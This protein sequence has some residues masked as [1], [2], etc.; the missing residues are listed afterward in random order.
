MDLPELVAPAGSFEHAETALR[1]GAD[2]IYAGVDTLNL[3]ARGHNFEPDALNELLALCRRYTA[4]LYLTLN[5]WADESHL[6]Q[7]T[8][9]LQTLRTSRLLPHAF[10]V[11]D[12]GI[13]SLCRRLCPDTPLH[14]STQHGTCNSEAMKFW[15]CRGVN[16]FVLPRELTCDQIA[17]LNATGIAQTEIFAHGAMCVSISGRCL[18]GA[19]LQGRHPNWGDC[20][21]PCRYAYR[22]Q[23][24]TQTTECREDTLDIQQT[25]DATYLLNSKDLNTLP[26]LNRLVDTGVTAIKIEG[27]NK[28]VHYVASVVHTYRAALDSMRNGTGNYHARSEWIEELESVPHR[29]YTTGFY[30]NDYT[31][32]EITGTKDGGR[33]RIVAIV[34]EP[35]DAHT[36]LA[37]VKHPFECDTGVDVLSSG[38]KPA[39][40]KTII[41]RIEDIKGNR[42]HRAVTNRIV[43]VTTE[44]PLH[45]GDIFR[46]T[47]SA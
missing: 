36:A 33:K 37:D 28:S 16:R 34:K 44:H 39:P 12:P 45:R 18:L 23:L 21:Q 1:Y 3:R 46:R 5:I 17:T 47:E 26:I 20:P 14:M 4:S 29:H 43:R 24:D 2:A 10:I 7:V 15:K 25:E 9:L 35:L 6:K 41:T 8:I 40:F 30:G 31:L 22:L 38:K 27:R 11:S 42:L 13:I 19:Y 32:Q